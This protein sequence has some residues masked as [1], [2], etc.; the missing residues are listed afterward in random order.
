MA[1]KTAIPPCPTR[2]SGTGTTQETPKFGKETTEITLAVL[3]SM[4]HGKGRLLFYRSKDLLDW[5]FVNYASTDG[6]G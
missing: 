5:E 2:I 1:K 6:L 3:G 4:A